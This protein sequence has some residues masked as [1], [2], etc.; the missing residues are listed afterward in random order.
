MID[1]LGRTMGL[2]TAATLLGLMICG[3]TGGRQTADQA[4]KKAYEGTGEQQAAVAPFTGKVTVDGKPPANVGL[5]GI[6]VVLWDPK[7]PPTAKHLPAHAPCDSEGNFTFT[8]Y[9]KGDGAPV[10]SYIVC[11]AQLKKTSLNA[12]GWRGPDGLK[13]LYNDPD[14]NAEN[15]EFKVDVTPPGKTDWQFPLQVEGKEPVGARPVPTPSPNFLSDRHGK[16][17]IHL[18]VRNASRDFGTSRAMLRLL[19]GIHAILPQA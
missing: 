7:N 14:K 5:G 10:G 15:K 18:T 12:P 4:R 11:F 1:N 16:S 3:C 8:T 2:T 17:I 9:S 13:N 19:N 6:F